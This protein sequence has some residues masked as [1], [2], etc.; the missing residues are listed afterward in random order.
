MKAKALQ[1]TF[2]LALNTPEF[3]AAWKEWVEHRR[4]IRK[5]LT[6]RSAAMSLKRC[7]QLGHDNAIAAI[8]H[9]ISGSYQAIFAAP[10]QPSVKAP[11]KPVQKSLSTWE[12]KQRLEACQNEYRDLVF[13]GGCAHAVQLVGKKAARAQDLLET[14]RTLKSQLTCS[15]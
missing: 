13:P 12:I 4:E 10:L 7:E 2:P 3:Q 14:I 9:S 8:E 6:E 11:A 5:P 1:I 15:Q